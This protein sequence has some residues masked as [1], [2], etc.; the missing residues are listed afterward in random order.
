M[1]RAAP[2]TMATRLIE[3][4]PLEHRRQALAAADAH[5]LQAVAGLAAVHLAQQRG[6]DA[7]AG[8]ADRVAERDARAVDVEPLEVGRR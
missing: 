5:G 7:A 2:V 3:D 4:D 6:E 8:R 1:P